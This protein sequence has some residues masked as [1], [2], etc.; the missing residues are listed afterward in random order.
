MVDMNEEGQGHGDKAKEPKRKR[1]VLGARESLMVLDWMKKNCGVYSSSKA[2]SSAAS[3][4]TGLEVGPSTIE[5]WMPD[6]EGFYSKAEGPATV[7]DLEKVVASLSETVEAISDRLI[8]VLRRLD[9]SDCEIRDLIEV[10]VS[11]D[12]H[13]ERVLNG[14]DDDEEGSDD[15][16]EGADDDEGSEKVLRS[17]PLQARSQVGG[18]M[19]G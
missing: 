8:Y 11:M 5:Y 6:V 2:A 15:D 17:V 14:L 13:E 7:K 1:R 16:E 9:R 10:L 12:K 19:E 3:A 18:L 4:A